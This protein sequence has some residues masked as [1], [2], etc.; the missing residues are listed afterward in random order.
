MYKQEKATL[1][2]KL[3]IKRV[4]IVFTNISKAQHFESSFCIS[5]SIMP[6][7]T[8]RSKEQYE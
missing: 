2:Q 7:E 1:L 4:S 5:T 8:A 3:K 6:F